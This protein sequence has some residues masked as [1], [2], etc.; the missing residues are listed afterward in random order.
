MDVCA[1][2]TVAPLNVPNTVLAVVAPLYT[3]TKS[4]LAWVAKVEKVREMLPPLGLTRIA[5]QV[6]L[7]AYR[8]LAVMARVL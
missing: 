5:M 7:L 8:A 2:G 6:S 1:A 4:W 3:V